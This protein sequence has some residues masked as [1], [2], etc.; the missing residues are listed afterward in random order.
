MNKVL[1]LICGAFLFVAV[2]LAFSPT[3]AGSVA[4]GTV[5]GNHDTTDLRNSLSSLEN[6][7]GV[8]P[9][10]CDASRSQRQTLVWIFGGLGVLVGV[11]AFIMEG[12]RRASSAENRRD[13][14]ISESA[15]S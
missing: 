11:G 3:H 13:R 6:P 8:T 12:Q 1:T 10:A 4:C 9:A 2:V 7:G 5:F 15:A 14:G